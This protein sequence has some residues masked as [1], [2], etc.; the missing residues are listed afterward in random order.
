MSGAT[1]KDELRK[2]VQDLSVRG[3]LNSTKFLSELIISLKP[4]KQ[5][6]EKKEKQEIIDLEIEDYFNYGKSLFDMKE[7][8][9]CH[10][11]LQKIQIKKTTNQTN[12]CIFLKLYSKYL[13]GEKRREEEENESSEKHEEMNKE[14]KSVYEEL[15]SLKNNLDPFLKYLFGIV[16]KKMKRENE[17]L[18]YF[19]QSVKEYPLLWCSWIEIIQICENKEKIEIIQNEI[20]YDHWI[21][22]LFLG[23]VKLECHDSEEALEHFLV[24]EKIFPDSTF[25]TNQIALGYYSQTDFDESELYFQQSRYKDPYSLDSLDVYSNILFVKDNTKELSILAHESVL[26]EKFKPETCCILGNYYSRR[27]NHMKSITY[28]KRAIQ[29]DPKCL[30][31]WTLMGHEYIEIKNTTEAINAYK[32]ALKINT[33]DYRAWYGLGQAYELLQMNLYA[34]YYY[35]KA[36]SL[37]PYDPRMWIA[38]GNIY[39]S[40]SKFEDAIK[41]Y[42][43]AKLKDTQGTALF[44]MAILY[45]IIHQPDKASECYIDMIKDVDEFQTN[46]QFDGLLYLVQYFKNKKNFESAEKYCLPLLDYDVPQREI[47]KSLLKEI[48]NLK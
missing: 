28:F 39:E 26:I 14:I 42:E 9:R 27:R 7:Y 32:S 5:Q 19:I 45:Q 10:F 38:L 30:S 17:S 3:L 46:E 13:Y 41:C 36:T 23:C 31:A 25:I 24:L 22:I 1:I 8:Q 48:R 47:A 16:L 44:K 11:Y 43:R 33:K 20:K 6:E 2:A 4:I 35:N 18:Q 37:K 12:K 15:N 21:K 29:L 34:L 40:I